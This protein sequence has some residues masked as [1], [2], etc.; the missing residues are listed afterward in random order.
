[1]NLIK[2]TFI[3][4]LKRIIAIGLSGVVLMG[5]T[6]P[7]AVEAKI[8]SNQLT[9]S[10]STA[11]QQ[12]EVRGIWISYFELESMLKNKS[13]LDFRRAYEA[14]MASLSKDGFNTVYVQV[15]PFSDAL[16]KSPNVP[17]SYMM[18]GTEGSVM[19][20]DPLKIMIEVSHQNHIQF[21]AWLNPYRVRIPY[22][23]ASISKANIATKWLNDKSNRAVKLATGT[24]F[25][26]SDPTVN[27]M[28]IKEVKYIVEN[29]QVDG[30]HLDDYFYPTTVSSFDKPQYE[31]YLKA[32]GK[33]KLADFRRQR[34]NEM[35]KGVYQVCKSNNKNVKFGI[36]PQGIQKNNYD[37][38]FADVAKWA[39]EG[40]YVDYI[41]PQI[42]YGYLN[43]TAPFMK[44]LKEWD[45]L[46]Q[47]SK[48]DFYVGL[49][50]YKVGLID[51]Y[52]HS[53]SLEWQTSKGIMRQMV[54]DSRL[55]TGYKGVIFFRYDSL[56]K[57]SKAVET[58]IKAEKELM[59]ELWQSILS[60]NQ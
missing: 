11:V 36:S 56:Y 34:I 39:T 33:L 48:V 12:Q 13:E 51:K 35:V 37:G 44:I 5:A 20:F 49:A 43:Q 29:Y 18:T 7:D 28:F 19:A 55:M 41:C 22:V 53:G 26:P 23:K 9:G 3:T 52:A 25:N 57:P 31:A 15:R 60:S 50:P 38:Q 2:H 21:E 10:P 30:I 54:M 27:A 16:Y 14:M 58:A 40:G 32:G 1:M 6:L 45:S 46:A 4:Q 42:Y 8:A 17:S 59:V 47:K 24:F